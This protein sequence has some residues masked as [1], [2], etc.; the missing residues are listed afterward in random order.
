MSITWAK[1]GDDPGPLKAS[2][3]LG[4]VLFIPSLSHVYDSTARV[5]GQGLPAYPRG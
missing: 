1:R 5:A 4:V 3:T 2:Y